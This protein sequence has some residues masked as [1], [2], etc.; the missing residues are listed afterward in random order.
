MQRRKNADLFEDWESTGQ[1]EMNKIH[2]KH[3]RN[4]RI[5]DVINRLENLKS[6]VSLCREAIV[7]NFD[8]DRLA[9]VLH[10]YVIE[11][12]QIAQEELKQV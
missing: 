6:L 12:I 5:S 4:T 11:Q 7:P 8:E 3:T 10:Y 1:D 9:K 2:A